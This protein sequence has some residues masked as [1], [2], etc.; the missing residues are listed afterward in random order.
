MTEKS[1]LRTEPGQRIDQP[2]L[3]HAAERS[4][5]DAIAQLVEEVIRG[6]DGPA[7]AITGWTVTTSGGSITVARGTAITG[8][9]DG[10]VLYRGTVL[11]GGPASRTISVAAFA[12]GTYGVYVRLSFRPS[13]V[14]NRRVW[15]AT[16]TPSP[17]EI[18]RLQATRIVED[19]DLVLE[20]NNPG[21]DFLL[22]G[23][24][25][26]TG[27]A[28]G[29]FTAASA[30]LFDS[31]RAN[32]ALTDADWG[33]TADRSTAAPNIRGL[34]RFARMV[35]RQLQDIIGG[36]FFGTAVPSPGT[37]GT[38]PRSLTSLN[39]NK[40]DRNGST[41]ITGDLTPSASGTRSLGSDILRFLR[42]WANQ[43]RVGAGVSASAGVILGD[44]LSDA[45]KQV[46]FTGSTSAREARIT[47][48][49]TGSA[50]GNGQLAIVSSAVL[51]TGTAE[52]TIGGTELNLSSQSV[53][54]TSLSNIR[55]RRVISVAASQAYVGVI[56]RDTPFNVN[57]TITP[58]AGGSI[59][60]GGGRPAFVLGYTLTGGETGQVVQQQP[61][62]DTGT[63]NRV[64]VP[65][66]NP[67][68]QN[69]G[70]TLNATFLIVELVS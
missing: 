45:A 54:P 68:T 64:V 26:I 67:V 23:T 21:D 14:R 7:T 65:M 60:G 58:G 12:D 4:Q 51:L 56:A 69:N 2:E 3:Q 43:V 46:F 70:A 50:A 5:K 63:A 55:I 8:Y 30:L 53:S 6:P 40:L 17:T 24:L 19:W 61:Y 15:N 32:R 62:V 35:M 38:G 25:P 10:G 16:A 39:E 57:F 41:T 49:P 18:A 48:D 47:H 11:A 59:G 13:V 33:S 1:Y 22:L 27:G 52:T 42:L 9:R 31:A 28:P 20:I 34:T 37:A 36:T 66:V 29:S 44:D